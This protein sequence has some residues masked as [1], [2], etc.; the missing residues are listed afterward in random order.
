MP[1]AKSSRVKKKKQEFNQFFAVTILE[2]LIDY[3][4]GKMSLAVLEFSLKWASKIGHFGLIFAAGLGFLFSLVFAIRENSFFAFL[5]G[6]AWIIIVF[7][8]QYTAFRFST[9]GETLIKNNPT[10]L[11][12]RAFL[13]CIAFLATIEGLV[14]LI[15]SVFWS[16]RGAGLS[17]LFTGIGAFILLEFIALVAFNPRTVTTE[18][19]KSTSAGQEAIGI[20]VFFL[21]GLMKLVPIFFG[22]GIAVGTILLFI[23][24]IGV[25]GNAYRASISWRHGNSIAFQILLFG[26]LPFLSYLF[27]ILCYLGIDVIRAIL[28]LP[29][30]LDKLKK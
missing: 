22:I 27:F 12:S 18:I 28:S 29:E 3:L 8:V 6:I 26:L 16:I 5:S 11:S 25:F 19:S 15:V 4:R 14:V 13:D 21:K 10:S 9:A 2:R 24:F 7:V 17:T 20:I 30:K 23:D 1:K